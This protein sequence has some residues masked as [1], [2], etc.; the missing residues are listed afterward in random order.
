MTESK[1][2]S[3]VSNFLLC[4][5]DLEM[6]SH[7]LPLCS[8]SHLIFSKFLRYQHTHTSSLSH[9]HIPSHTASQKMYSACVVANPIDL[10]IR[11]EILHICRRW[12]ILELCLLH[13]VHILHTICHL[14]QCTHV[15]IFAAQKYILKYFFS[16][17]MLLI[18][19]VHVS[20]KH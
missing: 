19:H 14:F 10:V 2:G 5:Q 6:P 18:F 15:L 20:V 17:D 1:I 16:A 12:N 8:M 11:F 9:T 4:V 7:H 13:L 3:I